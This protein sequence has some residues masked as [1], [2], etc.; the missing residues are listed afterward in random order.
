MP[1]ESFEYSPMHPDEAALPARI[2]PGERVPDIFVPL[3]AVATEG[4]LVTEVTR[5]MQRLGFDTF[6]YGA[7][8]R[9]HAEWEPWFTSWTTLPQAWVWRYY[10]RNYVETDPRIAVG[11]TRPTPLVWDRAT[12]GGTP[13]ADAFLED[14]ASYGLCSGVVFHL[15]GPGPEHYLAALNSARPRCEWIDDDAVGRGYLFATW[16]HR[17]FGGLMLRGRFTPSVRNQPLS[18]RERECLSYLAR[19]YTN[20][21][22]AM[23]MGITGRTVGYYVTQLLTKL[24]AENRTEAVARA[25]REKLI[26]S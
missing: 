6:T 20:A 24:E 23:A 18:P 3:L 22:I 9:L 1:K 17:H 16:F 5:A 10:S 21:E 8:I 19:G 15:H 13:A 4:E 12:L 7:A 25:L 14:A 26:G 11:F 2:D